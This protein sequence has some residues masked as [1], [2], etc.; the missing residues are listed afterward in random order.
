MS[1]IKYMARRL[2]ALTCLA[3]ILAVTAGCGG[4]PDKS[5]DEP[6]RYQAAVEAEPVVTPE[7]L[8]QLDEFKQLPLPKASPRPPRPKGAPCLDLPPS[9]LGEGQQ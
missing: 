2:P 3:T 5:C 7:D 6:Q 9:I 4:T 1:K 8:D